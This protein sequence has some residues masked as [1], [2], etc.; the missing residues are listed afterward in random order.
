[1]CKR[2]EALKRLYYQIGE[3]RVGETALWNER[4]KAFDETGKAAALGQATVSEFVTHDDRWYERE[5]GG[6][7]RDKA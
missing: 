1:M 7:A 5:C 6:V 3:D 4:I 2:R